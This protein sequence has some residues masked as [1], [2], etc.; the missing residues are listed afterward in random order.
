MLIYLDGVDGCGKTT[1]CKHLEDSIPN[2][3]VVPMMGAGPIGMAVKNR[4]TKDD[5]L[6]K[7]SY[8][9]I[10]SLAAGMEAIY[11]VVAPAIADGKIVIM[12]RSIASFWAYQIT[13]NKNRIARNIFNTLLSPK[14]HSILKPDIY[15]YCKISARNAYKRIY[16]RENDYVDLI[17]TGSRM[18]IIK[19]Y[20]SFIRK[21][22]VKYKW[23]VA[24]LDCNNSLDKV[25]VDLNGIVYKQVTT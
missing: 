6:F 10:S 24:V 5:T 14:M 7:T 23:N 21:A 11:D 22:T 20:E 13:L 17:D 4:F 8:N 16:N 1:L 15:I 18:C 25:I 12:D 19:G 3:V 2:S 9:A